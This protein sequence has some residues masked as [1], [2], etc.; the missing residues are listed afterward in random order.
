MDECKPD[1]Q[2]WWGVPKHCAPPPPPVPSSK[3]NYFVFKDTLTSPATEF[4]EIESIIGAK[5]RGNTITLFLKGGET[6]DIIFDVSKGEN[7]IDEV[8]RNLLK[9]ITGS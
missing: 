7:G 1:R 5:K 6:H 4:F 3:K 8:F 9:G 2:I